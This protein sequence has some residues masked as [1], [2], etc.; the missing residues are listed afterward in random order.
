MK[1]F[2]ITITVVNWMEMKI[3]W[4]EIRRRDMEA[5]GMEVMTTIK[6]KVAQK[7][8]SVVMRRKGK[9]Q[10]GRQGEERS[11]V[12]VGVVYV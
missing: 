3:N 2:W 5:K 12:Q 1:A 6:K 7:K 4:M 9:Y 8:A 10:A 11:R